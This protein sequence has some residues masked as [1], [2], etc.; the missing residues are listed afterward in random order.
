MHYECLHDMSSSYH[1]FILIIFQ[2]ST[3]CTTASNNDWKLKLLNTLYEQTG[4]IVVSI[5][6]IRSLRQKMSCMSLKY[7]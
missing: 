1:L 2:P 7:A 4:S 3:E 5:S 6:L